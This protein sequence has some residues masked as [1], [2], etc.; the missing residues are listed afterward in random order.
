MSILALHLFSYHI[1]KKTG[2]GSS[3]FVCNRSRDQPACHWHILSWHVFH[4]S[5]DSRRA[6]CQLLAKEWALNTGKL[7][8]GGFRLARRNIVVKLP[9]VAT[10]LKSSLP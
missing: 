3:V 1:R 4:S 6:S 10:L 8:P 9:A 2:R 5:T 7:P